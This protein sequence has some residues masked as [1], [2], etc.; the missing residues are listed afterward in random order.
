MS[1]NGGELRQ[2]A[3]ILFRRCGRILRRL[4]RREDEQEREQET[5]RA[6]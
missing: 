5:K 3:R 1:F 6:G 4:T 2:H